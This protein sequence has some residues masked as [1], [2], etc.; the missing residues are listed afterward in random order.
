MALHRGGSLSVVGT[1]YHIAGQTTAESLDCL[2]KSDSLFYLVYDAITEYWVRSLNP[3]AT[4][5]RK[6]IK[7][8]RPSAE[9]CNAMVAPIIAAVR[10]RL[11][12]CAAFSGHPSLCLYPSHEAVRRANAEG[13]PAKILPALSALDC[14]F[15]DLAV[16]P[17]QYGYRVLDATAFLIYGYKPQPSSAFILLQIANIGGTRASSVSMQ[18]KIRVLRKVLE[19]SY[20]ACQPVILYETAANPIVEPRIQRVSLSTLEKQ[21]IR[22]NTTLFIPPVPFDLS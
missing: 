6:Y 18:S 20:A 13:F 21:E 16:N 2:R 12:V 4:S 14:M 1:G 5:L 17:I 11:N 9:S 8:G 7:P 19:K 15:A 3:S 10:R 22:F